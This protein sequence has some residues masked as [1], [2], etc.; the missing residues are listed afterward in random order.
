MNDNG[1]QPIV[2]NHA[3]FFEK[4]FEK[5]ARTREKVLVQLQF[6]VAQMNHERTA[7]ADKSA[8]ISLVLADQVVDGS[9]YRGQ[10]EGFPVL[11]VASMTVG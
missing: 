9:D 4:S 11:D 10:N 7:A 1:P 5:D 8:C 2:Q 3:Q 6:V